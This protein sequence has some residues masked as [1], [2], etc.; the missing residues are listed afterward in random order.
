MKL[1][2]WRGVKNFGDLLAPLL[3]KR[4]AH[5]NSEWAAP[6]ESDAVLIGSI[7]DLMPA[8]YG[9]VIAGCGKLHEERSMDFPHAKVLAVR[10]PLTARGMKGSFAIGDPGL[11]AD[12]LVGYKDKEY[13]LGVIPHWTDKTLEFDPRFLKYNPRIIRVSDDPLHFIEEVAKCKKIVSSALHGIILADAFGIPRR[14]EISPKAISHPKQEGGLFKWK[15]YSESIGMKLEI[16]LTQDVN[17]N[18]ITERQHEIFDVF[19]AIR[20]EFGAGIS[21]PA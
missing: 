6:K 2:Y 9:G 20:A 18:K 13:N 14:I 12:E 8:D 19:E 15:D 17:H 5:I 7:L 10:G 3:L 4:F 21:S 16:G 1:Y 11:L